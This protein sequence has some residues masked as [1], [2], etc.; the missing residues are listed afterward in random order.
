MIF[1]SA[2]KANLCLHHLHWCLV[3][4]ASLCFYTALLDNIFLSHYLSVSYQSHV[5]TY[6]YLIMYAHFI[7]IGFDPTH[8]IV[9]EEKQVLYSQMIG[10]SDCMD[11]T[12]IL[13]LYNLDPV[14]NTLALHCISNK[15]RLISIWLLEYQTV[16]NI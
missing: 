5:A 10:K 7:L 4:G 3:R 12:I 14:Q 2:S 13:S 11:M 15:L 16:V 9:H 1:S 8:S 6:A